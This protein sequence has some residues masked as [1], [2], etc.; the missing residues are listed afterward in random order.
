[1]EYYSAIEKDE[2]ESSAGKRMFLETILLSE[3]NQTRKL[4]YHI[5]PLT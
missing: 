2:L 5:V 3:T 1:M 4:K